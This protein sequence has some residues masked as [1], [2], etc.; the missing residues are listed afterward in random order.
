MKKP[1]PNKYEL[2]EHSVQDARV[3]V[4][5]MTWLYKLQRKRKALR[6]RE[7]FCGTFKVCC[8]WVKQ[9][10][11]YTAMGVDLSTSPLAYG[12]KTHLVKLSDDQ[13]SRIRLLQRN[14]LHVHKPQ[15][16]VVCAFNFSYYIFKTRRELLNYFKA[17][18][19]ALARD[20][21][22]IVDAFG[23]TV[24]QDVHIERRWVKT[25]KYRFQ[26]IWEQTIYNP[27]QNS[28]KYKIHFKLPNGQRIDNAFSY[29]WRMWTLPEIRE[30]MIDAGFKKT[31]VYWEGVNRKGQGNGRFRRQEHDDAC[32]VW[33]GYLVGVK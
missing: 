31:Y 29:D 21:V 18:Y 15:V 22:M 11:K 16:D 1:I 20:G 12:R 19:K 4:D 8:E 14:V 5:F 17:S 10:P 25:R 2:Y 24:T 26:Y 9:G 33:V 7:D 6:L 3:E 23:G 30:T 27:I 28:A 13:Q 32:D